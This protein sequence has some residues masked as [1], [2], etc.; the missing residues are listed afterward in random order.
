MSPRR[1]NSSRPSAPSSGCRPSVPRHHVHCPPPPAPHPTSPPLRNLTLPPLPPLP[2]VAPGPL[3][4]QLPPPPMCRT[5]RPHCARPPP[6]PLRPNPAPFR[7]RR[8]PQHM[9]TRPA[10]P[11]L[12]PRRCGPTHLAPDPNFTSRSAPPPRPAAASMRRVCL[13]MGAGA[14]AAA[15]ATSFHDCH[16]SKFLVV[17]GD[18]VA[19]ACPPPST[20][21]ST[22][23][24]CLRALAAPSAA[25]DTITPRPPPPQQA[26]AS[27]AI[28]LPTPALLP[29]LRLPAPHPARLCCCRRCAHR[30]CHAMAAV[31][32]MPQPSPSTQPLCASPM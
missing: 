7:P 19:D 3:P 16:H 13:R 4:H 27:T 32:S 11:A 6:P 30:R 23:H 2:R 10:A 18:Y 20:T 5:P 29:P 22:R 21:A 25:A 12:N 24:I 14:P 1:P 15:D 17:Y 26:P 9:H 31:P 8:C 28:T